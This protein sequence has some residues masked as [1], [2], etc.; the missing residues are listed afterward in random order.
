M[1]INVVHPCMTSRRRLRRGTEL[2]GAILA[3]LVL[4]GFAL[5]L[6]Q[7]RGQERSVSNAPPPAHAW[8]GQL[9]ASERAAVKAALGS[10]DARTR[11]LAVSVGA[12]EAGALALAGPAALHHHGV[13][14]AGAPED[15]ESRAAERFHHR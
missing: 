14:T 8:P 9:A 10:P 2:G 15:H 4:A 12:G 1:G 13:N 5:A 11:R 6:V 3:L 7:I